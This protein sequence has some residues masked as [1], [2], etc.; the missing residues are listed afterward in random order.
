MQVSAHVIER[1]ENF[2]MSTNREMKSWYA[3]EELMKERV[4]G[5]ERGLVHAVL[6]MRRERAGRAP[7][8]LEQTPNFWTRPV[9]QEVGL[10]GQEVE[11]RLGGL[12][13]WGRRYRVIDSGPRTYDTDDEGQ[14][15][16][17]KETQDR[18]RSRVWARAR[19]C[20]PLP[21]PG[22]PIMVIL[23]LLGALWLPTDVPIVK[24]FQMTY[25]PCHP[26]L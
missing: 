1:G 18:C 10:H 21:H 12:Q 24:T 6:R 15:T 17:P 23:L 13:A 11:R 7:Q 8:N 3:E 26:T 20:T 9:L 19:P 14:Q 4:G 16:V 22:F 25:F 2:K 5:R